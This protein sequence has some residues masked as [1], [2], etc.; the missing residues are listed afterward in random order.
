MSTSEA[1]SAAGEHGAAAWAEGAG[2]VLWV[3]RWGDLT[4]VVADRGGDAAAGERWGV[5]DGVVRA[6]W[7]TLTRSRYPRLR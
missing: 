4:L 7:R 2:G 3:E 6:T 5:V 1:N